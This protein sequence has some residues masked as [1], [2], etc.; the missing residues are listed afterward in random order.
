MKLII[1]TD[2]AS[3]GNPGH[4]GYGFTIADGNGKL[5][6]EEGKYIGITTN[7]VA[8]YA[9]VLEALKYIRGK[10][11][12]KQLEIELYADSK[13]VVEQLSG[14][15]KVK[16]PHLKPIVDQ[17][18]ILSL[19]LGGAIHTHVPRAGNYKADRLANLALDKELLSSDIFDLS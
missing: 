10:Y 16:S 7:N 6:Y 15:Y 8:E 18:K 9:A 12:D 17:I 2:G 4:A 1:Y 5:L 11:G 14:R 3:R 13:L 19:E